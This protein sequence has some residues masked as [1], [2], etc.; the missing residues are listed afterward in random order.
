VWAVSGRRGLSIIA[1]QFV[2]H[3]SCERLTIDHFA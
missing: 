3:P 2:A 1:E